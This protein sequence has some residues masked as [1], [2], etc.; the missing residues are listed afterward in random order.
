MYIFI[1]I[2]PPEKRKESPI[3]ADEWRH[4]ILVIL[5]I[6]LLKPQ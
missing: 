2:S 1:R 6:Y 4:E 5:K 3:A